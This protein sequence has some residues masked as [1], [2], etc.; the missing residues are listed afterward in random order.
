MQEAGVSNNSV[1]AEIFGIPEYVLS[2]L[3]RDFGLS[4]NTS[5]L[6][7]IANDG[8]EITQEA[9]EKMLKEGKSRTQIAEEFGVTMGRIT[10]KMDEYGLDY[11][12][13]PRR[14]KQVLPDNFSLSTMLKKGV[15]L[16]EIADDYDI[17]VEALKNHIKKE[18][19]LA[20]KNVPMAHEKISDLAEKGYSVKEIAKKL[21]MKMTEVRREIDAQG[22]SIIIPKEKFMSAFKVYLQGTYKAKPEIKD[23]QKYFGLDN[24]E[25]SRMWKIYY[26]D[27]QEASKEF[28]KSFR[29]R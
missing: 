7:R 29:K 15:T 12:V 23:L 25:Y 26:D 6:T 18:G 5:Y 4:D 10:K 16:E 8:I 2:K 24:A 9:L 28:Y 27:I 11:T 20:Y 21:N 22:I 13:L 19:I 3:L 14:A 1:L 17:S